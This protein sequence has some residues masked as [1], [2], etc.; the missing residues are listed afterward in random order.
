M[1]TTWTLTAQD[2][3]TDALQIVG[4][5]GAGQTAAP[6]DYTVCMNALQ[7]IIKELPIHGLSW[8]KITAAPVV[9]AWSAG[10]PAQVAMPVD[11]F[12]VPVVSYTA[13]NA[14]I[15]LQVI[16]KVDYDAIQQPDYVAARPKKIYIAANGV[17]YLWPVPAANPGLSMTYQAIGIDAAL[18]AMPD[19]AQTWLGLLGLW[20]ANDVSIKF[21]VNL[22]DRQDIERRFLARRGLAL[23]YATESAPISFGVCG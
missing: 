2:A 23:A 21:G 16:P 20:I 17:G 3:I 9:L 22:G 11:Y 19:V 12:G 13:D 8:P 1:S 10:T 18:G 5:I 4:V 15:D 6:D 14:N 7:N